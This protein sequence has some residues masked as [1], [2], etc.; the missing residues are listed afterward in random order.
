MV[1]SSCRICWVRFPRAAL[2]Y[3]STSIFLLHLA[4]MYHENTCLCGNSTSITE[5]SFIISR[6]TSC[7][8]I[9]HHTPDI[10]CTDTDVSCAYERPCTGQVVQCSM[11][12][13]VS[14]RSWVQPSLQH[15][16]H[17]FLN[18]LNEA[19]SS[20]E[21]PCMYLSLFLH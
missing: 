2:Q 9:W 17:S 4:N 6:Q 8:G 14:P 21:C 18:R 7:I 16:L 13:L 19:K 5:T 11:T 10:Y 3:I 1:P 15:M 20:F 12:S